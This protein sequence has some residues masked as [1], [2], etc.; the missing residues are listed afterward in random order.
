MSVAGRRRAFAA[1]ALVALA[2]AGFVIAGASGGQ[3][4][5]ANGAARLV[6]SDA[7][8]YVHLSTDRDRDAVRRAQK[9]AALL[10]K[11]RVSGDVIEK[12]SQAQHERLAA[13]SVLAD[14][15]RDG[16]GVA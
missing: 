9:L 3:P 10:E 6:P 13:Q 11:T 1:V 8:V 14:S 15:A 4:K 16:G 7:L 12:V 5:I 2:V